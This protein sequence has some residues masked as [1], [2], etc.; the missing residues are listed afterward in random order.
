MEL[1]RGSRIGNERRIAIHLNDQFGFAISFS[2]ERAEMLWVKDPPWP[3]HRSLNGRT[4]TATF[5]LAKI[6]A[7]QYSEVEQFHL[8][9]FTHCSAAF[10]YVASSTVNYFKKKKTLQVAKGAG[11]V[12]MM[13]ADA[14]KVRVCER[15]RKY[16]TTEEYMKMGGENISGMVGY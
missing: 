14:R 4:R 6:D 2:V 12:L 9:F 8:R 7:R 1:T 5:T 13:I 11:W 15:K 16:F 3:T 10:L